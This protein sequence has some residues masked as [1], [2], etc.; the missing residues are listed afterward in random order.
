MADELTWDAVTGLTLYACRFQQNGDVFLTDG[1]SDEVWGTGGRTAD[2]YAVAMTEEDGS[3]HYKGDFD[4]SSNI[5][6]E[7]Y[8]V[9]VYMQAGVDPVDADKPTARGQMDWDGT[10]EI[11][12]FTIN[13]A[14]GAIP[15]DDLNPALNLLNVGLNKERT[16][17]TRS[18]SG[19][20][21]R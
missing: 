2:D 1:A 6:A 3:G 13:V 11:N 7:S 21:T 16:T 5:S 20:S 15:T 8:P 18:R 14:V 17:R 4:A 19:S 10:A 12:L 9:A